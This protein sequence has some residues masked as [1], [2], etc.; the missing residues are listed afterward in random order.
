MAVFFFLTNTAMAEEIICPKAIDV[1]Q[2]IEEVPQGF[3]AFEQGYP[4]YANN[5]S[6]YSGAPEEMALLK[7]DNG[8]DVAKVYKYSLGKPSSDYWVVCGYAF[9]NVS[10]E[11]KIQHA[12]SY[13]ESHE[14]EDG[15]R[16]RMVCQ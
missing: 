15:L 1:E 7:P 13:C 2:E 6:L 5:I 12:I 14:N 8:D 16:D 9:T 4:H 3:E 10:L 11:R